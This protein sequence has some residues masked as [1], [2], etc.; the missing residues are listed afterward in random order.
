[1]RVLL[2]LDNL[3]QVIAAA[4]DLAALLERCPWLHLLVTSQ[5]PLRISLEQQYPL[6]PL[7]LPLSNG[8]AQGEAAGR[9]RV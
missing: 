2:I 3:E 1:M 8:H 6:A 5:T 7:P 9:T 4:P